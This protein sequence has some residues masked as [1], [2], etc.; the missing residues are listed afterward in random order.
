MKEKHDNNQNRNAKRVPLWLPYLQ[1]IKETKKGVFEFVFNGGV[2]TTDLSSVSSIMIYGESDTSLEPAILDKIARKGIPI[3]IHRRNMSQPIYIFG[4]LRPDPDDTL[5]AQ[6][7]KRKTSRTDS[8]VARQLLIAKMQSMSYLVPPKN[9]PQ[10]ANIKRLRNIEAVHAR[11]YW[12]KFFKAL[13]RPDWSRRGRNPASE[14]LD[15][16][17]KFL[18]GIVLRWIT[19]HHMSPYHGFLHET[20]DYPSLVYDLIEPYRGIFEQKMLKLFIETLQDRWLP[21]SI[22]MLKAELDEKVYV[23]LTRQIVTR[24]ELLHGAVLSLKYYCLGKQ[25]KFLV[26]LPG[27]PNGGRPPKVNFLLYGRHAGKTDFWKVAKSISKD[28]GEAN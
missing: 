23:P 7:V 20:T 15:S 13:G 25:R 14:A 10:F 22:S 3:I 1:S 12:D 6:I 17:S 28:N 16:A 26:P 5:S 24:Q 21:A 9:V 8:H 2:E 27:K 18:T 4:G 19:Y 11:A